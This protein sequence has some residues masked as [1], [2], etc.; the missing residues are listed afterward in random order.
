MRSLLSCV[1]PG[2]RRAGE[3][4]PREGKGKKGG[5]GGG[6]G[7]GGCGRMDG[8]MAGGEVRRRTLS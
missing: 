5:G 1:V 2:R 3:A 4:R 7:D 6:G 8:W